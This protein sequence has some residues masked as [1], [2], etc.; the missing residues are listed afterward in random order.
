MT[1]QVSIDAHQHF[2]RYDPPRFPWIAPGSVLAADYLPAQLAPRLALSGISQTI[3]VQAEPDEAETRWLLTLAEQSDWIIGVVGWT[4]LQTEGVEARL[5]AI[6]HP[7]LVGLRHMVQDEPDPRFL[8]RPA[9]IEGVRAAMRRGWTY[10]LLL[11]ADQLPLA[12]RFIEAVG[13]GRLVLDHGAKPKIAVRG[14]EPW[15]SAIAEVAAFSN[16]WCKVSGLITEADHQA[17]TAS[18]IRPYLDHLLA[19]FGPERLIFGSDWPVCRL[20]GCYGQV[21]DLI[22][23]F[24]ASA[25]PQ[26][27]ASVFGDAA[28]AAYGLQR[29]D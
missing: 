26:H 8:L 25:C 3:A 14:W 2:W 17:W 18:D 9:F 13:E 28:R 15:A 20:A 24:V 16:V 4:D 5:D 22:A 10:D 11:V 12:P 27:A 6:A 19:C 29:G 1:T 7:R 21:H 23:D